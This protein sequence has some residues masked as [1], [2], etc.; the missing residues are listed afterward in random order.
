MGST[1]DKIKGNANDAAGYMKQAVG[2]A[3]GS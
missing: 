1:T 2:N 3:V